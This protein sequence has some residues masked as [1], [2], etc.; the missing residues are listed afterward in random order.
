MSTNATAGLFKQILLSREIVTPEELEEAQ[1]YAS[2]QET[3]LVKALTDLD[4]LTEDDVAALFAD[5]YQVRSLKLEDVEIDRE[6][7]RHIPA[8]VAH[9]HK[10]VPVRRSGNTLVVAMADPCDHEARAAVRAVTDFEIVVFVARMDGIEHALHIHYGEAPEE[11]SEEANSC[12]ADPMEGASIVPD[13]RFAHIGRSSPLSRGYTF[14]AYIE[15]VG[16]QY[17]L[18]LARS[19]VSGQPEDRSCPLLFWGAHG[20]GKTHLLHAI[21]NYLSAKEPLNKYILTTGTIFSDNLFDFMRRLKVNLL[22]YIYRD[23]KYLLLD[24]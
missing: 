24:D 5:A 10:L 18:N 7:I 13:E 19:V 21:A 4:V 8:S 17:P 2:E 12:D 22:R 9:R 11:F 3:T 16:C 1:S 20:C 23:A 15:D 14:D 6:S